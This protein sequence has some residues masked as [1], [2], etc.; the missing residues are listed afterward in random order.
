M[1]YIL[2]KRKLVP[3][4]PDRI[5]TFCPRCGT[6]QF[7]GTVTRPVLSRAQLARQIAELT[8]YQA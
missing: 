6:L 2:H 5:Y 8:R 1:F 3:I 7:G 4:D